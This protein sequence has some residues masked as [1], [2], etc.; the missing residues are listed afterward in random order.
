VPARE[1]DKSSWYSE[2]TVERGVHVRFVVMCVTWLHVASF[3]DH[4]KKKHLQSRGPIDSVNKDRRGWKTSFLF[5]PVGLPGNAHNNRSVNND[6]RRQSMR[7]LVASPI[8]NGRSSRRRLP[9]SLFLLACGAFLLLLISKPLSAVRRVSAYVIPIGSGSRSDPVARRARS[10]LT[11][12]AFHR[13]PAATPLFA[14]RRGKTGG[15]STSNG[16]HQ[17]RRRRLHGGAPLTVCRLA[18]EDDRDSEEVTGSNEEGGESGSASGDQGTDAAQWKERAEMLRQQIRKMEQ[19][20]DEER[21]MRPSSANPKKADDDSGNNGIKEYDWMRRGSPGADAEE[22][23]ADDDLGGAF[24]LRNKRVLVAGAN[25][26]LGS[27]V[28]RHLL[29]NYPSTQVV[30]AV[31]VVGDISPTARGYGR[32]SYEVGAED[33]VGTLGAAWSEQRTAT[34]EYDPNVMEGYN[35]QSL[36]IVEC[37]LLDPVQCQSVVEGCDAVIWCAT[38]FNQNVPRAVSSLNVAL[39][40][41]AVSRP[42][43]GR[44]DVEGVQNMMGAIKQDLQERRRRR[45]ES[46]QSALPSASIVNFVLVS[47]SPDAYE[48]YETPF[49]SFRGIKQQGE[50]L[51][52]QFPSLTATVLQMARY[53]DNFVGEGLDIQMEEVASRRTGSDELSTAD[54]S[55]KK[56]R[57]KINRRD[58]ARAAVEALVNHDLAGKAVQ[59]WTAT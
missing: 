16:M 57:R 59:V 17:S 39:L 10:A 36:R 56:S 28:C 58:A 49:G 32:L 35:L 48:D 8:L 27:M 38:D 1:P 37:E 54:T 4:G 30:A 12:A 21:K 47:T 53:E 50:E 45:G 13:P 26:R 15:G 29:R 9:S 2:L 31:H 7:F 44:V 22:G 46:A 23:S 25:G 55:A 5:F 19:Q 3:D 24:S 20:L 6:S 14:R 41:R 33:G 11:V 34:F 51:M 52:Q 40:F 42:T 18:K 43:K